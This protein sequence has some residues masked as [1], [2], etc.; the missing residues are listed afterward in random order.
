M[1]AIKQYLLNTLNGAIYKF[2]NEENRFKTLP[3]QCRFGTFDQ[4]VVG[5]DNNN[6]YNNNYNQIYSMAYKATS[7]IDA[8]KINKQLYA[9]HSDFLRE[10]RYLIH[11]SDVTMGVS[12]SQPHDCL[13]TVYSDADQR[14]H[15]GF[16][17]LAFVWGIHR[18]TQ[19]ASNAEIFPFDDVIMRISTVHCHIRLLSCMNIILK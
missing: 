11:Y 9:Y 16:A 15:H 17:S 14:Q 7:F 19:M 18:I 1:A 3:S 12:N 5:D 13:P 8:M 6:D 2:C 10:G 4:Y